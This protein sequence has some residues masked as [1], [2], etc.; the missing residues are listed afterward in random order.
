MEK[1]VSPAKVVVLGEGKLK[2]WLMVK[3]RVGKTSLTYRFVQGQFN[4]R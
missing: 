4:E 3:G 2:E 1:K